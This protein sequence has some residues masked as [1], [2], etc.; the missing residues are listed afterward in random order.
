[1]C[2]ILKRPHQCL[3]I[4]FNAYFPKL[5]RL[6]APMPHPISCIFFFAYLLDMP[7]FFI[8]S[9]FRLK[10]FKYFLMNP[11]HWPYSPTISFQRALPNSVFPSRLSVPGFTYCFL[12]LLFFLNTDFCERSLNSS[13]GPQKVWTLLGGYEI[14]CDDYRVVTWLTHPLPPAV[15]YSHS[16]ASLSAFPGP[17]RVPTIPTGLLLPVSTRVSSSY[18]LPPESELG[19]D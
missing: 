2:L 9:L 16:S 17:F 18:T 7:S 10:S 12:S 13:K 11:F 14:N 5:A 4:A 1:M 6:N 8:I 19:Y 15:W 3:A